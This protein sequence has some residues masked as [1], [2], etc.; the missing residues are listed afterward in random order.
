VAL[1]GP[2]G[3]PGRAGRA[4]RIVPGAAIG[5]VFGAVFGAVVGGR[6][7]AGR[8]GV[9]VGCGCAEIGVMLADEFLDGLDEVVP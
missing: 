5:A 2:R 1:L 6:G 3:Q 4:V 9:G 7:V 8:V